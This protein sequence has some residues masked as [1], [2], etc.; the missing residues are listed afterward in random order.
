MEPG[1]FLPGVKKSCLRGSDS[2]RCHGYL[3][4]AHRDF[5]NVCVMV[6]LKQRE[7]VGGRAQIHT[8]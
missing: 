3:T 5:P 7:D 8:E 1:M 4:P 2:L 6:S